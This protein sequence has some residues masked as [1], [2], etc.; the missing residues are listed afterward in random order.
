MSIDANTFRSVLGRF[1]SGV[2]ILT[3]RDDDE[4]D[5]GMT[6]SSFCSLSLVPPMVLACVDH[7]ASMH[8]ALRTATHFGISVLAEGQEAIARRF[9][10]SQPDPFEGI[11][12]ARGSSGV[13]L[14]VEALAHIECRI[15]DRFPGGDHTIFI[16]EVEEA[17]ARQGQPL[18]YYRGGY[19]TIQR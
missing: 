2:T 18:L 11:G 12:F 4:V 9:A 15:V 7:A 10:C 14:V 3:V 19:A 1:A 6:V 5:R 13:P 16:G 17:E 8:P